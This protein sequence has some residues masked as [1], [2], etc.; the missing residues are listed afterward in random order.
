MSIF[1]HL[2][3]QHQLDMELL[4]KA[5]N[6]LYLIDSEPNTPKHIKDRIKNLE[7]EVM[8]HLKNDHRMRNSTIAFDLC[9]YPVGMKK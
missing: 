3:K 5:M 4:N 1:S 7:N 6:M 2:E 9:E 8:I